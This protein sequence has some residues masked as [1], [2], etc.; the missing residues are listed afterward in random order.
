MSLI[1]LS[2]IQ[3]LPHTD[4]HMGVLVFIILLGAILSPDFLG[5]F[6]DK[7]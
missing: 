2:E 7:S 5:D 3:K 1:L 4:R 6:L